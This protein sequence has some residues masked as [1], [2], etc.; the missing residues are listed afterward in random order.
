MAARPACH[1]PGLGQHVIGQA[2]VPL[3]LTALPSAVDE[4]PRQCPLERT[5]LR[6]LA[7]QPLCLFCLAG[8]RGRLRA[9]L[10]LTPPT[11]TLSP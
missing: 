10:Q 7:Q 5:V 1:R 11:W 9:S 3:P 4:G 8:L 2:L 6:V